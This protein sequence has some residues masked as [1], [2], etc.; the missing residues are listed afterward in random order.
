IGEVSAKLKPAPDAAHVLVGDDGK[1]YPLVKDAGAR[2][3]AKDKRLLGRPMRLTGRLDPKSKMLQVVN[4]HSL[5][6]GVLHDV[7]YWCD[8]CTIKSFEN[9]ICDCCGGPVELREVKLDV[10]K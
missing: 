7:Y 3:F 8:I 5:K 10:K 1:L 9:A 4:V 6:N 2:L